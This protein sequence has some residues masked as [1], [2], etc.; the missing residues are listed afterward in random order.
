MPPTFNAVPSPNVLVMGESKGSACCVW[1]D[2]LASYVLSAA[3]VFDGAVAG[4]PVQWLGGST[5]GFGQK[6]AGNLYWM[7]VE[8][9]LLDAGLATISSAGSFGSP[10]QYPWAGHVMEWHEIPGVRSVVICGKR[11]I[12]FATVDDQLAAG[13]RRIPGTSSFYGRLV[14]LRYDN[15]S[16]FGGDSGAAVISL[17]EGKLLGMHIGRDLDKQF[18]LA[19][20][21]ADVRDTFGKTFFGFHLRP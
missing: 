21:A 6:L 9:G 2:G 3:H 16:T 20:P 12:V 17:P 13:T 4:A 8:G 15:A 14:R 18:S 7:P 5:L 1:Q 11:G 10:S 19:V